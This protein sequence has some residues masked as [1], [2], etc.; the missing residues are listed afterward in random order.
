MFGEVAFYLMKKTYNW[1]KALILKANVFLDI[2]MLIQLA[3]CEF[4]GVRLFQKQRI[5]KK[6]KKPISPQID[7]VIKCT[8]ME[9]KT[10]VHCMISMFYSTDH[11][12]N[13]WA[14]GAP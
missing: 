6:K 1:K 12:K 14:I 8:W 11:Q 2:N 4:D 13:I 5:M 3:M 9:K 10:K 7:D